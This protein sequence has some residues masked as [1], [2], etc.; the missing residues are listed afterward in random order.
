MITLELSSSIILNP[1]FLL[2]E[3]STGS[4]YEKLSA[5]FT[6]F[7]ANLLFIKLGSIE[8][9]LLN[10]WFAIVE[11]IAIPSTIANQIFNNLSSMLPSLINNK[12]AG[13][14]VK[15]A[16]NFSYIDPVDNSISKNQGLRIILDDNSRVIIRLSGTW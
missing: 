14:L 4:I 1:W 2:I 6:R 15:Q 16:D 13:N 9:K 7:P 3:L 8:D 5:C 10:I 11:G 12:F